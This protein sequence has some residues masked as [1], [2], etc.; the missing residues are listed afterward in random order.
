M[1][2]GVL[3]LFVAAACSSPYRD[4]AEKLVMPKKKKAKPAPKKKV[5]KVAET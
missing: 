5:E 4:P 3:C 2:A 1:F